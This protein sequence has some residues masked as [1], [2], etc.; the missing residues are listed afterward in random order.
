M[1]HIDRSRLNDALKYIKYNLIRTIADTVYILSS[2]R[3]YMRLKIEKARRTNVPPANHLHGI[4]LP[5]SVGHLL[6]YA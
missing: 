2:I 6:S 1:I 3:Y 4:S 5:N